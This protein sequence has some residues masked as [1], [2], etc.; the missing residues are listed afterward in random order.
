MEVRQIVKELELQLEQKDF[1]LNSLLYMTE[2]V[3]SNKST[4]ELM[5]LIGFI[6][7]EQLGYQRFLLFNKQETWECVLKSGYKGKIS[8]FNVEKELTRFKEITIIESSES[9]LLQSFDV[10]IPVF[11]KS[12][13]LAYFL[14]KGVD[15]DGR[16]YSKELNYM[17]FI[18]TLINIAVVALEN[19]RMNKMGIREERYKKDMEVASA[20]QQTLFP[21]DLPSNNRLDIS[22]KYTPRHE[23]GGDYYD[24]ILLNEN[25][26]VLCIGDVSGKGVAAAMLM[27]NFQAIV[28]TLLE[29]RKF[30]IESLITDLNRKVMQISKG[31][32]FITFFI[33]HYNITTRIL[34]YVNAGHNHPF[35]TNGTEVNYL[36]EGTIGLGMMEEI[37]F[38]NVAEK[39]IPAKTTL[40]LYTDGVVELENEQG[41]FF[42]V[43][44]LIHV[45]HRY[46][47]LSMD[48]LNN[49]IFSNLDS[50]KGSLDFVDDT[51]VF[52]CRF[53]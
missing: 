23:V 3:N 11:Y 9:S 42:G 16:H 46:Y 15:Y 41:N 14:L 20:M 18:Q 48:D 17:N 53:F 51:A 47:P 34:T 26:F 32:K 30:D 24:F 52:S 21:Q 8:K 5:Q 29:S 44:R 38:L 50:W 12:T 40:M 27:A 37:P 6:V 31:D 19:R 36:N 4:E 10:I 22:A 13:P 28:R 49:L 2:A 45:V 7:K 35:I 43:E 33:A 25:E 39:Y 1:K